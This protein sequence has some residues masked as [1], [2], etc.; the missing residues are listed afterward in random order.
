M[1][2]STERLFFVDGEVGVDASNVEID[3]D[4]L[5][6]QAEVKKHRLDV[7]VLFFIL[8]APKKNKP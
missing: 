5:A 8:R 7:S 4:G 3:D 1:P 2:G 6:F